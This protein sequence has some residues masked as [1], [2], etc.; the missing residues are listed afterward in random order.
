MNYVNIALGHGRNMQ[1]NT[2]QVTRSLPMIRIL[3]LLGVSLLAYSPTVEAQNNFDYGEFTGM[4]VFSR[5]D[6]FEQEYKV[7]NGLSRAEKMPIINSAIAE[8]KTDTIPYAG[9]F[10]C[11]KFSYITAFNMFG[12]KNLE[13]WRYYDNFTEEQKTKIHNGKYNIPVYGVYT[14]TQGSSTELGAETSGHAINAIFVGPVNE[15][16]KHDPTKFNQW[17]FFEPQNDKE[18]KPGDF[19]MNENASALINT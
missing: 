19:S 14:T 17:Y 2:Y 8:D 3:L 4:D 9:N 11:G 15:N 7:F 6:L 10:Q 16:E 5:P 12:A 18:V 13:E 1:A